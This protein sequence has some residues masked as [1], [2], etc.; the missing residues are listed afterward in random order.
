MLLWCT[1]YAVPDSSNSTINLEGPWQYRWGMSLQDSTGNYAWLAANTQDTAWKFIDR[2]ELIDD[3]PNETDLWA[4][5]DLPHRQTAAPAIFILYV[6]ESIEVYVEDSLVYRFGDFAFQ[7]T[8]PQRAWVWHLVDLPQDCSGRRLT[9]HVR[10]NVYKP[11]IQGEILF[12]SGKLLLEKMLRN[13]IVGFLLSL[14]TILTGIIFLVIAVVARDVRVF[15]GVIVAPIGI[16]MFGLFPLQIMQWIYFAPALYYF[17]EHA[18]MYI[19]TVGFLM[20]IESLMAFP[21]QKIFRRLWQAM[22]I[23]GTA[24]LIGEVTVYTSNLVQMIPLYFIIVLCMGLLFWYSA[25]SMRLVE[26][27]MRV[28]L[29]ALNMYAVLV[30]I[31]IVLFYYRVYARESR[32]GIPFI[33]TGSF[34][35]FVIL[36]WMVF[37]HYDKMNK[38]IIALQEDALRN[39]AAAHEA[40]ERQQRERAEHERNLI[41]SRERERLRIAQDLHDEIGS[42]LTEIRIVS[43]MAKDH[44]GRRGTI[45]EK[46]GELSTATEDVISTFS[47]IVWSL[48]PKNDSLENLAAYIGQR[49]I[50]FLAKADIRCRLDMPPEFPALKIESQV[51]HHL[52]LATKETLNNIVKHA[53]ASIVLFGI[54][55][56]DG[57]LSIVI[58]DDGHGFD[59]A[60]VRNGGNG[61]TNIRKRIECIGGTTRIESIFDQGTTVTFQIDTK[62]LQ[63]V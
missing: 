61:L 3:H 63:A 51:R 27:E 57:Q 15:K 26:R 16:G 36:G 1:G 38:R 4:R 11:S 43:E 47:E 2:P 20:L 48:N 9:L 50:D 18:G 54:A 24:M 17:L 58:Q 7:R 13:D 31:E 23:Y 49:A 19:A 14:G 41:L 29:T 39:Q 56:D 59:E 21:Y 37:S 45:K 32:E 22:T 33:N 10:S 28:P 6:V 30:I 42:R 35:L 62:N 53:D 55:I 60:T 12:G 8:T 40:M 44:T 34:F 46:L 5:T 25:K 52:I